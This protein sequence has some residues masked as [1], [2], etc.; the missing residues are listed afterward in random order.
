MLLRSLSG[1]LLSLLHEGTQRPLAHKHNLKNVAASSH[2]LCSPTLSQLW[3]VWYT[4]QEL[5]TLSSMSSTAYARFFTRVS[6][7]SCA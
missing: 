2:Q 4:V 1:T 7:V 5:P 3:T 6:L